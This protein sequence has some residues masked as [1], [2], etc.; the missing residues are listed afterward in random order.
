MLN[1]CA[2]LERSWLASPKEALQGS[3]FGPL[4]FT[5]AVNG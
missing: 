3:V 2:N 5:G 4:I 1:T